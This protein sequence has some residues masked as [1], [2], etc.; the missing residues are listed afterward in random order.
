MDRKNT[1]AAPEVNQFD[2]LIHTSNG[3]M[4]SAINGKEV[5]QDDY[6]YVQLGD[7]Y[8]EDLESRMVKK[9]KEG[10]FSADGLFHSPNGGA[11]DPRNGRNLASEMK[12]DD[13]FVQ[14]GLKDWDTELDENPNALIRMKGVPAKINARTGE[15][16]DFKDFAQNKNSASGEWEDLHGIVGQ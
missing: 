14:M 5:I 2:G 11:Y 6:D 8:D 1:D 10:V 16:Q 12:A 13:D 3:R 4:F 15:V 7:I 9:Q